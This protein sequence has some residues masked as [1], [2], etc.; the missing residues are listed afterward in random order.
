ME[1]TAQ[2]DWEGDFCN[3]QVMRD[4]GPSGK[5]LSLWS[6]IYRQIFTLCRQRGREGIKG[7]AFCPGTSSGSPASSTQW[8]HR[9][10]AHSHCISSSPVPPPSQ[11]K[12]P[13]PWPKYNH[14]TSGC[15]FHVL[16]ED[17][18]SKGM[19]RV[20]LQLSSRGGAGWTEVGN[21][22]ISFPKHSPRPGLSPG[23]LGG[24]GP[25]LSLLSRPAG[26][27]G[28][29]HSTVLGTG[30]AGWARTDVLTPPACP[31]SGTSPETQCST[32]P[33]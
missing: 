11:G 23:S 33:S 31:G 26:C 2:R 32:K 6:L 12:C 18:V 3:A 20:D 5:Q 7:M 24:E 19:L 27:A 8:E 4:K 1:S 29:S 17:N 16:L 9:C 30:A 28:S 15:Q 13:V 21:Q 10:T 25:W 22:L 14:N